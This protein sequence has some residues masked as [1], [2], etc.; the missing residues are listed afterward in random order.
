MPVRYV[1]K[2]T[3]MQM[4]VAQ[5]FFNGAA[6]LNRQQAEAMQD[7]L[8]GWWSADQILEQQEASKGVDREPV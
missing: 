2:I 4:E 7:L 5:A 6:D 8:R 3:G 1:A